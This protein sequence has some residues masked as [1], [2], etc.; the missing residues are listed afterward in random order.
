M[1]NI[2]GTRPQGSKLVNTQLFPY[3]SKWLSFLF[4]LYKQTSMYKHWTLKNKNKQKS[5]KKE[6]SIFKLSGHGSHIGWDQSKTYI[7]IYTLYQNYYVF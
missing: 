4:H 7:I 5:R 3:S 2:F 6:Q 1:K